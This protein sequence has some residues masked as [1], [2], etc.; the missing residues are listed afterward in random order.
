MLQACKKL[1]EAE[2][3]SGSAYGKTSICQYSVQQDIGC[4]TKACTL[5]QPP[6]T[7]RPEL[8]A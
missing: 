5:V 4:Q 1:Q 8:L 6:P 2:A 7:N 3:Y